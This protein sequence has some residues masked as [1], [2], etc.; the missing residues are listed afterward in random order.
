MLFRVPHDVVQSRHALGGWGE[1]V[2]AR[3]YQTRGLGQVI[4]RN[5]R[6]GRFELD[7]LVQN[8]RTLRVVEVRTSTGRTPDA[9]SWSLVGRKARKLKEAMMRLGRSRKFS[10]VTDRLV[11]DVAL[12]YV[13]RR[14]RIARVEVWF[15][16]LTM[17][18]PV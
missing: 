3:W 14:T 4:A 16:A 9:L 5:V 6:L 15:D 7:L 13:D 2:V 10:R 1:G 12:V 8:G 18:P 11:L 17:C